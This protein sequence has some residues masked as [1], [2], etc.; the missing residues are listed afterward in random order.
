MRT[1]IRYPESRGYSNRIVEYDGKA[2]QNTQTNT[3]V[4]IWKGF[5]IVY[6]SNLGTSTVTKY[7]MANG[8]R[9]AEM[10]GSAVDYYHQDI[11]GST[12]LLSTSTS[13]T[14][15][16]SNYIPY[17]QN[18]GSAGTEVFQYTGEPEDSVTGY[19]NFGARYYDPSTGRFITEDSYSG[20]KEDPQS[21]TRPTTVTCGCYKRMDNIQQAE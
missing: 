7:F 3:V 2:I 17:G 4:S 8:L 13:G 6:Q 14:Q 1:L 16:S 19:Y 9:I 18:Y 10:I 20:D 15:F 12:R 11:L 5:D 21:M